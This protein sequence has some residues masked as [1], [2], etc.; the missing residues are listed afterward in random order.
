MKGQMLCHTGDE[1]TACPTSR[2]RFVR[3]LSRSSSSR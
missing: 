3:C 1:S 2:I